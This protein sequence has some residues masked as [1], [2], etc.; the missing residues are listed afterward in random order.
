MGASPTPVRPG[1]FDGDP[2]KDATRQSLLLMAQAGSC[3]EDVSGRGLDRGSP[4]RRGRAPREGLI[5]AVDEPNHPDT[6]RLH[7]L[8]AGTLAEPELT[9]VAAHLDG[10]ADCRAG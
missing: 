10:C 5:L 9:R 7:G 3:R 6:D 2:G 8:A 1:A 4:L